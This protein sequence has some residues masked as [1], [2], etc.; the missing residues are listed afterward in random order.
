MQ[1]FAPGGPPQP[2]VYGSNMYTAQQQQQFMQW[3]QSQQMAPQ[4]MTS[5]TQF[6][7]P[8]APMN[9]KRQGMYV[10]GPTAQQHSTFVFLLSALPNKCHNLI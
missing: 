9:G 2:S 10:Y 3:Q 5:T 8:G 6:L 4:L 7:M 1:M